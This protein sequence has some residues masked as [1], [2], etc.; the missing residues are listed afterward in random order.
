MTLY[1]R[2]LSINPSRLANELER[3]NI[4][5][6]VFLSFQRIRPRSDHIYIEFSHGLR[7]PT[8]SSFFTRNGRSISDV[9]HGA[10]AIKLE[11]EGSDAF[12]RDAEEEWQSYQASIDISEASRSN[13]SSYLRNIGAQFCT[14]DSVVPCTVSS[15]SYCEAL[16]RDRDDANGYLAYA[17]IQTGE[18][19][20]ALPQPVSSRNLSP[21]R[22]PSTLSQ[23][24]YTA[25]LITQQQTPS[26]TTFTPITTNSDITLSD[27]VSDQALTD[28]LQTLNLTDQNQE[29][30]PQLQSWTYQTYTENMTVCS[31]PQ[32]FHRRI[33]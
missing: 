27:H 31:P 33:S 14:S 19:S 13:H 10:T 9:N 20:V 16:I 7:M 21:Y 23:V 32:A 18:T 4:R 12:S 30:R 24:S 6:K 25:P 11:V 15:P 22:Q 5:L 1:E 8:S 3:R 17:E 29:D 26:T 2:T 28:Y